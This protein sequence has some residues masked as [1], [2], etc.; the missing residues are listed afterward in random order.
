MK[1]AVTHIQDTIVKLDHLNI[2]L[3]ILLGIA[4]IIIAFIFFK[5]LNK[6][7]SGVSGSV[8]DPKTG[9]WSG[10]L[11]SALI[12]TFLIFVAHI[13]WLKHAFITEDFGLLPEILVIDYSYLALV[14]GLRTYEKRMELKAKKENATTNENPETPTV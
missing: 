7:L 10:K 13:V 8:K 9:R 14:Y 4:I 5:N 12:V 3:L 2:G 1:K 6:I 11:L